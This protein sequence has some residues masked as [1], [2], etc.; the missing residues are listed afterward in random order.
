METLTVTGIV[1]GKEEF[2]FRDI[3]LSYLSPILSEFFTQSNL[4]VDRPKIIL[5]P[6]LL[7]NLENVLTTSLKSLLDQNYQEPSINDV[8]KHP[9]RF[10]K[11]VLEGKVYRV[12]YRMSE[13]G[14]MAYAIYS[15][16]NLINQAKLDKD[17]ISILL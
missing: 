6:D 15:Y 13:S 9:S 7:V 2:R 8:Q 16:I 4:T 12:N 10:E 14:W 5:D 17:R 11:I 1:K 3:L